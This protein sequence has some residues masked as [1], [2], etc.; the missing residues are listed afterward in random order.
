MGVAVLIYVK[1]WGE[2]CSSKQ[3]LSEAMFPPE[4]YVD[5]GGHTPIWSSNLDHPFRLILTILEIF[6]IRHRPSWVGPDPKNLHV[7]IELM[8]DPN[9]EGNPSVR[10][11]KNEILLY[12]FWGELQCSPQNWLSSLSEGHAH[13]PQEKFSGARISEFKFG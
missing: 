13:F 4:F 10:G 9:L 5:L 1:F 12:K 2:Q 3:G 11:L 8:G 7:R 6:W